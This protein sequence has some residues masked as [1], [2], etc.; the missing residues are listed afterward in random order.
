MKTWRPE[1]WSR[2]ARNMC[3]NEIWCVNN[4]WSTIAGAI[5]LF[6][7]S[8]RAPIIRQRGKALWPLCACG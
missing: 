8:Y 3:N 4:G 7:N 2:Q 1:S 5:H 6:S